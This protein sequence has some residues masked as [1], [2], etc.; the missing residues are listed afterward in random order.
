[1]A[2]II[3]DLASRNLI[4]QL[5][6]ENL[7][8]IL[9]AERPPV[10]CGFDPTNASLHLGNLLL[11]VSLMRF[12]QAGF[13]P[14]ILVGGATGL[15]GDPSGK[16]AERIL[17]NKEVIEDN[18]RGI[19]VQFRRFLDF[20]P[21]ASSAELVNNA[22]WFYTYSFIDFLRDVGKHFSIAAMLGKEAV[23]NRLA[24]G[25]SFT[26]F[27]YTLLQAYDF[28]HLLDTRGCRIQVGGQDQWGNITAGIDL[29]R[30]LRHTECYGATFPLLTDAAGR[31][32]GKSV[33]GALWLDKN[34]TS[35]YQ[36]YQYL[37]NTTDSDVIRFLK[38]FTFLTLEEIDAYDRLLQAAP[39]KREAQKKLAWEVTRL[40]HGDEE[41]AMARKASEVL[42]GGEI[43]GLTD[44]VLERIFSEVP[45]YR[46]AASD[47]ASGVE[48]IGLLV[49]CQAAP[50]RGAAR[51]LISQG[52]VYI[53]NRQIDESLGT[54]TAEH[55]ASEHFIVLRTG[56]KKYCLIR[57]A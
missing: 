18:L 30:K 2:D 12:Q 4:F 8:S 10:Y 40:V 53:N 21:G 49:A 33:E 14:I 22:E 15:I 46:Y 19:E 44:A 28:L 42:F 45:Q 1:M 17:L 54:L 41:A 25:L 57:F 51:R 13:K 6:Y 26:E 36:L 34:R 50:S 43:S 35:P 31:K 55:L 48:M 3:T 52:G 56:K 11:I 5:T 29:I 47:L 23:R 38:Y 39:E 32:F 27:S 16:S 24:S 20:E 37:M 9:S 7:G